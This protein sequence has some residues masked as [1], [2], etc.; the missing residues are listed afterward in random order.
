MS[1]L[2]RRP[3]HLKLL[4]QI[5]KNPNAYFDHLNNSLFKEKTSVTTNTKDFLRKSFL[6]KIK[7]QKDLKAQ[8]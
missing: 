4:S 2:D 6:E 5:S 1:K 3:D 8:I 7:A